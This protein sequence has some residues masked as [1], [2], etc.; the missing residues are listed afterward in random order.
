MGVAK[1]VVASAALFILYLRLLDRF[2]A[3]H[4]QGGPPRWTARPLGIEGTDTT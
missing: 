3:S 2:H 4:L 1:A